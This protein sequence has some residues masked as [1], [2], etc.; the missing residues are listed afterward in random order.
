MKD[1]RLKV[2]MG[3]KLAKLRNNKGINQND[4]AFSVFTTRTTI[5]NIEAGNQGMTA[6]IIFKLSKALDCSPSYF[7]PNEQDHEA[8]IR[9]VKITK[10]LKKQ[11]KIEQLKEQLRCLENGEKYI[12]KKVLSVLI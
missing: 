10:E 5:T 4:L 3:E 11:M 2:L 6:G 1:E 8:R 12:N 9:P 7:F